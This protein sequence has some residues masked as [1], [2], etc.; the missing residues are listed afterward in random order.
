MI[1]AA[2]LNR[3]IARSPDAAA[4]LARWAGRNVRIETPLARATLVLTGDGRL[5]TSRAEPEAVLRLPLAFFIER[6]HNPA[7]AARRIELG[8]DAELGGQV[9]HA[10]ALLRWDTA[11]ELSS[12]VG[13]ALAH[14]ILRL[15]GRVGG[16][17]GAI[18]GRLLASYA[19]YWR[20]E[21]PLLPKSGEVEC[22]KTGVDA[23]RDDIARLEK[24]IDRLG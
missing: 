21:E 5:G 9:G 19:E 12:L 23:L 17:P 3:L 18:G 14:R 20:D 4:E 15:A 8:G 7:A 1:L 6:S 10:L 13:D 16:L 24:R 11:E 22:W 2:A